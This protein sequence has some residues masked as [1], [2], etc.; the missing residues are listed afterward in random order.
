MDLKS[1]A[2]REKIKIRPP[3]PINAEVEVPGSKSYSHRLLIGAALADGASEITGLLKSEDTLLTLAALQKFGAVIK[4]TPT[5]AVL[6]GTGGHLTGGGDIYLGNSGTSMRLLCAVAALSCG[7]SILSG[8]GRMH[9]RPVG[10]LLDAL[11]QLHIPAVS[12][13]G[14]GCPPVRITGAGINGGTVDGGALS[15]DCGVSSQHLSGLLLMA[16][17]T[18]S[19]LDITVTRGP[20]SRPYIRM[21][22]EIMDRLGVSAESPSDTRYIVP[23]GQCFRAGRYAVEP[24]AS[25]SSYFWA[26]ALICGGTVSV[27]GHAADSRQGDLRLLKIFERMGGRVDR[28]PGRI[29]VTGGPLTAVDVD[30]GDMPDMVPT[31]SVVA[32]FAKG[33]TRIRNVAHL[34]A[35]ECDRMAA[36]AAELGKMGIRVDCSE[37][38]MVICG[39]R[40]RPAEIRTY[41]DHRMAM[42]FAAA[43]L[44]IPGTV[45]LDPDCVRKS[46]PGFWEVF[47]RL[48]T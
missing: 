7:T 42:A 2:A 23:G 16:P 29:A 24:D 44:G 22:L 25:N 40:P 36:V 46:F 11:A 21:T 3:G 14:S 19:G 38:E 8:T 17:Y 1:G 35:K 45:I 5:G 48:Y 47:D 41:D 31:L 12:M 4:E 13:A 18:R 27:T 26:A 33:N 32:A 20:V 28:V 6:Q 10:E 9:E 37:S 30:M 34:K 43:G 39:G 15:V